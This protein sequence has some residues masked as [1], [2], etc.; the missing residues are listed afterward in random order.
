MSFVKWFVASTILLCNTLVVFSLMMPLALLK[1]VLP[2]PWVRR[3]VDALLNG[4]ATN[5]I[6]INAGWKIGRAHV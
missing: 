5:W 4:L 2:L 6:S 3:P 1:L